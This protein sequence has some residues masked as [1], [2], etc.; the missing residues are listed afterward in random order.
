MNEVMERLINEASSAIAYRVKRDIKQEKLSWEEEQ[1]YL[2][3]I[4]T[5]PKVQ[6]VLSWQNPDGYFGTRLHTAPSRSKVWTH[7]GCVRYL[8][9][10]GLTKENEEVYFVISNG[11]I[12]LNDTEEVFE[13]GDL[14][15]VQSDLF[16]DVVSFS[17]TF[18][19]M[20]NGEKHII[21]S[22]SV[23][24][25][26]GGTANI[27]GSLGKATGTEIIG[28][29]VED[30]DNLWFELATTDL[31]GEENVYQIQL[32]LTKLL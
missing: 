16:A 10:M 24:D 17:T 26:T 19:T 18:Y 28:R 7:E 30:I 1:N 31:N 20:R 11:S 32:T 15:T 9:E 22:N 3:R 6:M 25:Q 23:I 5:E 8:L 4:C 2:D 13:G 21:L 27:N 12:V 14:E 29:E